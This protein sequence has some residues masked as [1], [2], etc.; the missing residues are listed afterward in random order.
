[1]NNNELDDFCKLFSVI[2]GYY[3]RDKSRDHAM[4]YWNALKPYP[5]DF[6]KQIMDV[7]VRTSKFMPMV[8]DILDVV[9]KSDGRPGPQ[10]AWAICAPSFG[11]EAATVVWT[12]EMAVAMGVANSAGDAIAARMA[13][14]EAY[15]FNVRL[16]REMRKPV[17][18]TPSLGTDR[19]GRDGPLLEAVAAGRLLAPAVEP[20]LIGDT[21][22]ADLARLIGKSLAQIENRRNKTKLAELIGERG[23]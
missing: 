6:I 22:H 2:A 9:G 16:A 4:L 14:I 8:S 15:N 17:R 23:E 11:N 13:F 3:G 21:A 5:F 19:Y 1:M 7:H 12:N 18:W 10:E 20:L